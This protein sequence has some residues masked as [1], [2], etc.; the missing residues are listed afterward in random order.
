[1][2]SISVVVPIYNQA[3]LL[4]VTL[5]GVLGQDHP[6]E[7]ILVDDGSTDGSAAIIERLAAGRADVRLI[8]HGE[9]RGRAAA[10]NTGVVAA[11]GEVVLF[12]DGDMQPE[13]GVVRAHASRYCRGTIG[14]VSRDVLEGLDPT[15]SF[16]RYL[17]GKSGQKGADPSRPLPF[18][19]FVIGYTS[20]RA[21]A[22]RAV[23]GFDEAISY[24]ED[25]DLAYRL[26]QRWPGGLFHEP[27][28]VVHQYDVGG[29]DERLRKLREFGANLPR[30][31]A[32]HPGL[33]DAAG[34]RVVASPAWSR[35]LRP[36]VARLARRMLPLAPPDL[37]RAIIRYALASAVA[38]GLRHARD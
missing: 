20:V 36:E 27:A 25:L 35:L 5:P 24:G 32:K 1:M 19:Y 6:A 9:N 7:I 12:F 38:E 30:L 22:L 29:L 4:P 8:R 26:W 28:A 18:R 2:P 33:A 15:D 14:V 31:L 37:R 3:A 21:D 16:H 34:L 10:R 17:L 13:A 23:G 11:T